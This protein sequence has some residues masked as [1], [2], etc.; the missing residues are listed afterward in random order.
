MKFL[1]EKRGG[2]RYPIKRDQSGRS[3]RQ[4]AFELFDAGSRPSHIYNKRLVDAS[5]KTL[6]RYYEDWKRDNRRPSSSVLKRST[7][8]HPELAE[9]GVR[10]LSA[11]LGIP[12]AEVIAWSQQPW[13]LI[14]LL[15][16][17]LYG[18]PPETIR[19]LVS[20]IILLKDNSCMEIQ[21]ERGVISVT[22]VD[23]DGMVKRGRLKCSIPG[24]RR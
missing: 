7:D 1:F 19:A 5:P 15:A 17:Q 23:R 9:E 11:Q 12:A 6:F 13:G 20:D 21:K 3:L 18:N 10:E 14:Q 16:E 8:R 4:Q 22:T 24:Q 2:R